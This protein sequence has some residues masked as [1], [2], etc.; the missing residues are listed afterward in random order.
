[1]KS[2]RFLI[3]NVSSVSIFHRPIRSLISRV[4]CLRTF[5]EFRL[6]VQ[7]IRWLAVCLRNGTLKIWR[8]LQHSNNFLFL[9]IRV[10]LRYFLA[11]HK[12]KFGCPTYAFTWTENAEMAM[13]EFTYKIWLTQNIKCK[14]HFHG[15]PNAGASCSRIH[16][17][18]LKRALLRMNYL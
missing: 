11:Q 10:C 15:P 13:E 1:M 9:V 2:E 16:C 6:A 8:G 18:R 12:H 7:L 5:F 4:H 14:K 3:S 17:D